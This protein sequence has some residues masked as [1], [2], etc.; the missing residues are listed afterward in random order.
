MF[1]WWWLTTNG[2]LNTLELIVLVVPH[3]CEAEGEIVNVGH[4]WKDALV[5]QERRRDRSTIGER[6]E[7]I[8]GLELIING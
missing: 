8:F 5:K 7:E 2:A 3:K 4:V 6:W 1:P